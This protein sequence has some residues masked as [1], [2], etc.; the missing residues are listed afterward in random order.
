M[1]APQSLYY[2]FPMERIPYRKSFEVVGYTYEA[3][4]HCVP[5]ASQR[6]GRALS[7]RRLPGDREGNEVSPVFLDQTQDTDTC[8]DCHRR[9]SD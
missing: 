2:H 4:L 7:R 9:L 5:C 3:D 8:G 6:F 1:V